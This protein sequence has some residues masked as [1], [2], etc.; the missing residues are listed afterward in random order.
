MTAYAY[1]DTFLGKMTMTAENDA[2]TGLWFTK[3]SEEIMQETDSAVFGE[4]KHWLTR[5]FA[6]E[7][8]EFSP[9]FLLEGTAFRRTVWKILLTIPYGETTTY[10]AVASEAARIMGRARMS[11]QAAGGAIGHN[12]VCLIVPC[13]RVIGA[14]GSLTGY[15]EGLW[16]KEA[17]LRL[18]STGHIQ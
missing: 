17:L 1:F 15:A 3:D 13:H 14:D 5:Y 6:G 4:T 12:P 8:P 11:A 16:R 2:L 18:E 10:G 9:K 7:K